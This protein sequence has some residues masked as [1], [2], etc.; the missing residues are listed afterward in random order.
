MLKKMPNNTGVLNNLAYMLAENNERLEDALEYSRRAHE[1]APDNPGFLDTYGYVLYKNNK[2]QEADEYLQ[3]ALQQYLQN[4]ISAPA[5]VHE[6]LGM[7]KEA[8]GQKAEAVEAYEQALLTG[9][10]SLS[11]AARE[12][13]KTAIK[14]VAPSER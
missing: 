11:E 7:V 3:A 9:K 5:E 12:R 6:H 14:R 2:L 8:L 10:E 13:I 4:R 1:S